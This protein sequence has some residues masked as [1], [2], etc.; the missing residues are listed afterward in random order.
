MPCRSRTGS[1]TRW[2]RRRHGTEVRPAD[3]GDLALVPEIDDRADTVF[4]MAGYDLPDIAF[5]EGDLAQAKAVFVAGRPTVGYVAVNE[6]DGL[7]HVA[8]L[9]VLPGAMRQGVGTRLLD[10]ACDGRA[11]R[12]TTRSR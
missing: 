8:Q 5:D 1:R 11:G 2:R 3:D 6:V 4:R 12:A 9:A 10:R 7:A